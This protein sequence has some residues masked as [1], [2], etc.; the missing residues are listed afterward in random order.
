M[1]IKLSSL[2]LTNMLNTPNLPILLTR[3]MI[4]YIFR[5]LQFCKGTQI[6]IKLLFV[7]QSGK[8][9]NIKNQNVE[10]P[11]VDQKFEKDQNVKSWI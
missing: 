2:V 5:Y 4:N 3:P 11:K 7:N 9:Q 8:N 1:C 6:K 10:S